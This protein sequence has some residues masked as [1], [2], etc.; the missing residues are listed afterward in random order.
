MSFLLLME[1]TSSS[2]TSLSCF[3]TSI[4]YTIGEI[5]VAV[6]ASYARDWL[7]LKWFIS[8]YFAICLPY[9]YFIPESPYWLLSQ[10]KYA[11]LEKFLREICRTNGG[12]EDDWLP[13]FQ[14]LMETEITEQPEVIVKSPRPKWLRY[15]PRLVISAVIEFVTMLLY[16]KISYGLAVGN[17][18]ISPYSN[19]VLG[20][21]VEGFGYLMA[22]ILITTALGRKH[23][24]ILF[25]SLTSICVLA[26]PFLMTY[27]PLLT[28][29]VSQL[30]KLTVS[31]TYAVSWIYVPELF[32]TSMR[33]FAN[34]VFVSVGSFGSILAPIV[35]EALGDQYIQISFYVYSALIFFL[36]CLI[37]PLPET[38]NRSF[39]DGEES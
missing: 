32:P 17:G 5:L 3:I 23:S 22:S 20:A 39:D 27:S 38:R 11:E 36:V 25:A 7:R 34:A 9:V 13:S 21:I 10:K 12:T 29:I 26:I 28:T 19:M 6:F 16:T 18:T 35:D 37:F 4:A 2:H 15:L 24:L 31:S 33:G 1:L 14:E 8:I 30:G